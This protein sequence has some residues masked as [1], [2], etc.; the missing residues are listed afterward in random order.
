MIKYTPPWAFPSQEIQIEHN[1]KKKKTAKIGRFYIEIDAWQLV[2]P[3]FSKSGVGISIRISGGVHVDVDGPT[4]PDRG[5]RGL[6]YR[7]VLA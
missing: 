5:M 1:K 7:R 2:S 4:G 6:I 3:L